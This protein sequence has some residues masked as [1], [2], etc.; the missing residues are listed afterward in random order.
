M[1]K[2]PK[3]TIVDGLALDQL[4]EKYEREHDAQRAATAAAAAMRALRAQQQQSAGG[5]GLSTAVDCIPL[6]QRPSEE[7]LGDFSHSL[8]QLQQRGPARRYIYRNAAVLELKREFIVGYINEVK[9]TPAYTRSVEAL[10]DLADKFDDD[11]GIDELEGDALA[12]VWSVYATMDRVDRRGEYV[13]KLR[14]PSLTTNNFV[15]LEINVSQFADGGGIDDN[16]FVRAV[17]TSD[18]TTTD[19]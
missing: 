14:F 9:P 19:D 4:R 16:P 12:S 5:A 10:D 11:F 1:L 15:D 2:I 18:D 8:A 3:E 17:K 13:L 7:D 6:D